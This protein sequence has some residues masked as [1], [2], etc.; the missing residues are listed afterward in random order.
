M[1]LNRKWILVM[2]LVLSVAIATGSTLAY[3][4]ATTEKVT[5]TFTLGNVSI[6]LTEDAWGNN[7]DPHPLYPGTPVAKDP[8]ITNTGRTNAWVWM[9]MTVPAEVYPYLEFQTI[10]TSAWIIDDDD[11]AATGEVT[12]LYRSTLAPNG[13]AIPFTA[14]ELAED[15]NLPNTLES[16]NIEIVAYAIQDK[17]FDDVE[18][19][20]E[21]FQNDQPFAG[22]SGTQEDPYLINTAAQLANISNYSDYTY[23]KVADGVQTLDMTGVGRIT[24]NGSFDGNGVTMN[25]LSTSL[26]ESVGVHGVAKDI[27]ISNLTANVHTTDGR[28]LVRNIRNAGTTTFENVNLHGY[29]EGEYNMGS[30]YNYGTANGSSGSDYT[31]S[32]VNTKSDATLVCTTGNAIGGMLGHGYEGTDYTLSINMDA[33]SGYSGTMYTTGTAT[34]YEVMAMCSHATYNLNGV[35][36]SRYEGTYPSTRLTVAAPELKA[37]GYYVAPVAGADHYKVRLNAQL[38]AYDA[39]GNKI[40]NKAGITWNA[41][42]KDIS[43]DALTGKVF[44]VVST[45]SIVNSTAHELGYALEDGALTLYSGRNDGYASGT[46]TL[47]VNQYNA[48]NE[49]VATGKITVYTFPE[50]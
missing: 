37:D 11:V 1:K 29:I 40:P 32:F 17:P 47:F 20:Y 25:N 21:A 27:K 42:S 19:A 22:G 18:E 23:F 6:T 43:S 45:A 50:P 33:D 48:A 34:C 15:A 12:L 13:T 26:F 14:V 9:E 36:K 2:S 39:D 8:T 4:T 16:F 3:M 44:D 35:E 7:N 49:L 30:F 31:V 41:G 24:L 28:A 38:T 5:N 10:D 46:V